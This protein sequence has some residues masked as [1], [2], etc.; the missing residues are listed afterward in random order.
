MSG[1]Q[2]LPP[3]IAAVSAGGQYPASHCANEMMSRDRIIALGNTLGLILADELKRREVPNWDDI[4]ESVMGRFSAAVDG[5]SYVA[6][7][8]DT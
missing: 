5:E 7:A 2:Q 3:S 8:N 6:A 1:E 4:A